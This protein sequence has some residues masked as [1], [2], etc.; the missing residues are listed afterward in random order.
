MS[1]ADY[2]CG[3]VIDDHII[4][5]KRCDSLQELEAA[6]GLKKISLRFY[7]TPLISQSN[8]IPNP[9]STNDFY[10]KESSNSILLNA[11]FSDSLFFYKSF[12]EELVKVK[13]RQLQLYRPGS[14]KWINFKKVPDSIDLFFKFMIDGSEM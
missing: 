8:A 7:R 4:A 3:V 13:K 2:R 12:N 9:L 1:L 11:T 10:P 14:R 5:I 6:I